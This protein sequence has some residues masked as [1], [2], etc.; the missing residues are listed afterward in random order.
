MP[1]FVYGEDKP[2]VLPG[3]MEKAEAHWSYMDQYADR[4][5]LRGP[6][7]TDDAEEHTGSVHVV[8]VDDRAE[9]ER[10]AYEEPYW[11]AGFYQPLTVV[12][13]VVLADSADGVPKTLVTGEWPA[14]EVGELDG[15]DERV[16][17]LAMLVDDE[18]S[19]SVGIVAA[20]DAL[21]DKALTVVQPIADGLRGEPAILTA[22]RWQRGGRSQSD[23]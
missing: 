19:R 22:R 20:V 13:A 8:D 5:I 12:Q 9:A 1:Y 17:F 6:T 16:S 23:S 3:L 2:G 21:P 10:F 18:G 15:S 11:S 4:L 14:A 7:L